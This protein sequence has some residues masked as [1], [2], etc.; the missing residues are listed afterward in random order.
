M[1]HVVRQRGPAEVV[2]QHEVVQAVLYGGHAA[3][4]HGRAGECL[5]AVERD[6]RRQR[7][8]V[9]HFLEALQHRHVRCCVLLSL[10]K[11]STSGV[12]PAQDPV[13]VRRGRA[14][15]RRRPRAEPL[16]CCRHSVRRHHLPRVQHHQCFYHS[17]MSTHFEWVGLYEHGFG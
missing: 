7:R 14:G 13:L 4:T 9:A 8:A 6:Q 5:W 10:I 11:R 12:D 3:D 15:E 17:H 16:H 1:E 2:D